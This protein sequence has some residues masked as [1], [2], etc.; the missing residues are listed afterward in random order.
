M[1][2]RQD[3]ILTEEILATREPAGSTARLIT[4]KRTLALPLMAFALLAASCSSSGTST[5]SEPS[6]SDPGTSDPVATEPG[7]TDPGPNDSGG[8]GP[9]GPVGFAPAA[10]QQFDDCAAFLDYVHTEGAERVGPYGFGGGGYYGFPEVFAGEDIAE[11]APS[12]F[13]TADATAA[14]QADSGDRASSDGG[15][16]SYSTTNVQVD[17]VD[18]PDIIKTDGDRILA[19]TGDTL[20]YIDVADDG[21]TGTKRGSISLSSENQ[22][23]YGYEIFVSGDRAVVFAQ[24]DSYNDFVGGP[25]PVDDIAV[26]EPAFAEPDI[27]LDDADDGAVAT[28][29]PE[30]DDA[31]AGFV[32]AAPAPD[33]EPMPVDLPA[34]TGYV[35]PQTLIIEIDL[36]NPDSLAIDN[37]M[38]V[39][40]RYI[41]ARSIGDTARV[42]VTS[43]PQDLGFLYPSNEGTE[44]K[45]EDA[46]RQVVLES[47]VDDWIPGYTVTGAD[48]TS[49]SGALVD[50]GN[51]HAPADFGG[52]D[53]LSIVTL[54]LGAGIDAP[55]GTSSV[56]AT[57]D[58]VYASQDRMYI[59]T[60]IW[61][62]VID[63]QSNEWLDENYQTAVHRFSIAGEGPAAYEASGSV[64]GHLLNQ[65]SMN[66]RDGTFY[67]AT[68]VGAPWNSESSESQIVALQ[69][70]GDQLVEVGQVGGLGKGERIYSVRYV[71]DTAY[72]VTFRQTD[73]FY[74]LDLSDP[75]NMTVQGELKIPGFSSYLHP[76]GDDLVLGV[77]QDASDDGRTTGTKVSLFDV[78][79]PANPLE[80]DVWTL[81]GSSS[82]AQYDH[83]AFLWW[84]PTNTAVLP[85]QSYN[86][87]FAG[88][89]VLKIE[90]NTI[91]EQGRI[92]HSEDDEGQ[93][94]QT[95]CRVLTA[96]EVGVDENNEFF[97][98]FE[99]GGQVQAC[100]ANDQGGAVGLYCS[101]IP[102]EELEYY[103]WEG[104]VTIDTTGI[105][106]IELCYP[107][108]NGY[109]T[110][111]QRTMVIDGNLW[112]LSPSRVQSNDLG[113]LD[114]TAAIDLN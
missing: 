7:V 15:D 56:M 20:H 69:A 41:S 52:F 8:D 66:D 49:S 16:G 33:E 78:S 35:G 82:D 77:G 67:V 65:F 108:W 36:S 79:D 62:P 75:T 44:D 6:D 102:I 45:A 113:S 97:W 38:Q 94:G 39:D 23:A 93:I 71:G 101:V 90:N 99:N 87:R 2:F 96:E 57:G 74:V 89:V 11:E 105:E 37:T 111:V 109:E 114:R 83:R 88:A 53:M 81:D 61:E 48:G 112:T 73:P 14:T 46:N 95:D 68:T 51:I 92:Q 3:E 60:N 58:T 21:V 31:E 5:T 72:V 47:T 40:G 24:G 106:S 64:E 50:C 76:I 27:V 30:S 29:A 85:L 103:Y 100:G 42:V 80:V 34:P 55:V 25:F 19:I 17:G 63:E 110:A 4:M 59:T 1:L 32:R 28:T 54:D 9:S 91:T 104:E 70:D 98:V 107:D 84:A 18:E 12:D 43:P 86:D 13:D 26:S 10:L 22:Y